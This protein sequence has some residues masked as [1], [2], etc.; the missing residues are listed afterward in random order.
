LTELGQ[1]MDAA[2]FN[3]DAQNLGA[4]TRGKHESGHAEIESRATIG[5]LVLSR[6]FRGRRGGAVW[7]DVGD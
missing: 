1:L 2:G 3:H 4:I 6:F 5:K 7:V